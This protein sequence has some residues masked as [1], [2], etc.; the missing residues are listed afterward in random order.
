LALSGAPAPASRLGS[1]ALRAAAARAWRKWWRQWR[2][3]RRSLGLAHEDEGTAG[4]RESEGAA[5]SAL[6]VVADGASASA[7]APYFPQ[8]EGFSVLASAGSGPGAA[9]D[10]SSNLWAFAGSTAPAR[11]GLSAVVVNGS[12]LQALDPSGGMSPNGMPAVLGSPAVLVFGGRFD[13]AVSE[14]WLMRLDAAVLPT[15]ALAAGDVSRLGAVAPAPGLRASG[16]VAVVVGCCA[17]LAAC[18]GCTFVGSCARNSRNL[19]HALLLCAGVSIPGH[20]P[21]PE[22]TCLRLCQPC[23]GCGGRVA[24]VRL[25][26]VCCWTCRE[27]GCR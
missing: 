1:G 14:L 18:L 2:A 17:L 11:F 3:L 16:T 7:A 22:T 13:V 9:D 4:E 20:C 25:A 15:R 19:V 10:P 12:A 6:A 27:C 21:Q 24:A 5:E 8:S 23:F 26:R